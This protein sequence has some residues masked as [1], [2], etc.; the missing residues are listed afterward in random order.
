MIRRAPTNFAVQWQVYSVCAQWSRQV[1]EDGGAWQCAHAYFHSEQVEQN[2]Q[3]FLWPKTFL[4]YDKQKYVTSA[5]EAAHN[6][7]QSSGRT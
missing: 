7:L 3:T 1:Q 2:V 6:T 5:T 4:V